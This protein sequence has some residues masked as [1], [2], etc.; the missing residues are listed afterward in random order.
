MEDSY[1]NTLLDEFEKQFE[2]LETD[3]SHAVISVNDNLKKYYDTAI[4]FFDES[5]P[6]GHKYGDRRRRSI[7]NEKLREAMNGKD[8]MKKKLAEGYIKRKCLTLEDYDKFTFYK[9]RLNALKRILLQALKNSDITIK[10]N[11]VTDIFI[12]DTQLNSSYDSAIAVLITGYDTLRTH[13]LNFDS[14]TLANI[15][16]VMDTNV[17]NI[18]PVPNTKTIAYFQMFN[19]LM[20]LTALAREA[21]EGGIVHKK[22]MKTDTDSTRKYNDIQKKREHAI[23]GIKIINSKNGGTYPKLPKNAIFYIILFLLLTTLIILPYFNITIPTWIGVSGG[24]ALAVLWEISSIG[25]HMKYNTYMLKEISQ[26]LG[27]KFFSLEE[28]KAKS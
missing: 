27:L 6:L 24:I 17:Q 7:I 15:F 12:V 23:A 8:E 9:D 18:D 20:I 4:R 1:E 5:D 21:G 22:Q 10:D 25:S 2:N 19:S 28:F 16:K 3:F 14:P 26:S 13:F 11:L